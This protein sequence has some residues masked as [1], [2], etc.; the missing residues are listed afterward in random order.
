MRIDLEEQNSSDIVTAGIDVQVA[1]LTSQETGSMR[2]ARAAA[3]PPLL[4]PA[5]FEGS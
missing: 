2:A 5:V 1:V 4:P 3:A